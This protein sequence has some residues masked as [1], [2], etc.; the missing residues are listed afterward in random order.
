M[1]NNKRNTLT[2]KD[3]QRINT[4]HP[5]NNEGTAAWANTD[6]V[7]KEGNVSIPSEENVERAKNWVDNGNK[8]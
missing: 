3:N 8:L 7:C 5:T 4:S 6:H 1:M 2:G